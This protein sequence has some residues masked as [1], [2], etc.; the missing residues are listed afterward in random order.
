[1]SFMRW[2]VTWWFPVDIFGGRNMMESTLPL[3]QIPGWFL[4]ILAFSGAKLCTKKVIKIFHL[5][6]VISP[7]SKYSIW[8]RWQM[9][10]KLGKMASKTV[11]I[12][13]R[14]TSRKVEIQEKKTS[15]KMSWMVK[16]W[17]I[18]EN[19]IVSISTPCFFFEMAKNQ[20]FFLVF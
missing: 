3:I 1:M 12:K 20:W 19:P 16:K 11:E 9:K 17:M 10:W 6:A 13:E 8:K 15:M 14:K 2:H 5:Y 7:F 18:C 4:Q